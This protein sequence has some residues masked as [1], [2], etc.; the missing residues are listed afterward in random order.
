VFKF[1]EVCYYVGF[2][3]WVHE[4]VDWGKEAAQTIP[5]PLLGVLRVCISWFLLTS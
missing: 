5:N 3:F 2:L 4:D 1:G